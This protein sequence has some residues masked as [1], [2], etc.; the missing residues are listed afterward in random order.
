MATLRIL[1][2]ATLAV[3]GLAG[4]AAAGTS[5]PERPR[6]VVALGDSMTAGLGI[7]DPLARWPELATTLSRGRLAVI[8]DGISGDMLASAAREQ[9]FGPSMQARLPKVLALHPW[10][11]VL[12]GGA[13]D[14][15]WGGVSAGQ[16]EAA[17][18]SIAQRVE[19]HHIELVVSTIPPVGLAA[20][21]SYRARTPVR[22]AVNTW[23]RD[24]FHGDHLIDYYAHL[25]VD[26]L[27]P[28]NE[29]ARGDGVHPSVAEDRWF[30]T[31]AVQKL[32][33]LAARRP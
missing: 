13:N 3:L 29:Q 27:L 33:A 4:A 31:Q 19:A 17:I 28:P 24:H 16:E 32:E 9:P 10:A 11:I 14:I 7:P 5:P 1:L 26:G 20:P 8:N 18:A 15:D 23:I 22:D 25:A 12:L 30:A 2:L 6:L 21:A